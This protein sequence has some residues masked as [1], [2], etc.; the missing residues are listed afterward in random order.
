MNSKIRILFISVYFIVL[1]Y[2]VLVC[3]G[4][5]YPGWNPCFLFSIGTLMVIFIISIVG[6]LFSLILKIKK[7]RFVFV[8]LIPFL[9]FI[10]CDILNELNG[11]EYIKRNACQVRKVYV[12]NTFR[13]SSGA[14]LY[15]KTKKSDKKS[16]YMRVTKRTTLEKKSF[17]VK[18]FKQGDSLLIIY[19]VGCSKL[20][21]IYKP[22]PTKEEINKCNDYGY[23]VN[24]LL[25]SKQ[26]YE[27]LFG[28]NGTK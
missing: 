20:S 5:Y 28:N 21:I 22:Y 24:G 7:N 14:G 16:F 23:Y 1:I 18:K 10:P 12:H 17:S 4:Y 19:P 15:L 13:G 8:G 9:L 3:S 11:I 2:L 25:Y 26:E 27:K 6:F